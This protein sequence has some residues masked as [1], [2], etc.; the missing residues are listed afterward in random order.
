M[1]LQTTSKFMTGHTPPGMANNIPG[2]GVGLRSPVEEDAGQSINNQPKFRTSVACDTCRD[3]KVKCSGGNPCRYCQK[4]SLE[5]VFQVSRKRKLFP[6]DHV[7]GLERRVAR[8]EAEWLSNLH[9]HGMF[10]PFHLSHGPCNEWSAKDLPFGLG[11]AI[12]Q[13][14]GEQLPTERQNTTFQSTSP[15]GPSPS[16]TAGEIS[17]YQALSSSRTFGAEIHRLLNTPSPSTP[18]QSSP[19]QQQDIQSIA[20]I[21]PSTLPLV[22]CLPS[23][24]AARKYL[25]VVIFYIGQSQHFI[26]ARAFSDNL[27]RLYSN[28]SPRPDLSNV[29][30]VEI[31]LV[32]AVGRQMLHSPGSEDSVSSDTL[33]RAGIAR[34]PPFTGLR[35]EGKAII[36]VL[37]LAAVY[38]QNL[39]LVDDAYYYA[40]T[41]LR[42]C[43]CHQ[44]HRAD[45]QRPLFMSQRAHANR[46]WWTVY[47]QERRL[48]A[49]TGNPVGIPDNSIDIDLPFDAAGFVP[50]GAM[51]VNLTAARIA[52]QIQ[53]LLYS[54]N[55]ILQE[56]FVASVRRILGSLYKATQDIPPEHVL[57]FTVQPLR[58][59]RTSASL[60]LM[61]YQSM[62]HAIRPILLHLAKSSINEVVEWSSTDPRLYKLARTCIAAAQRSLL[63]LITLHHD[64][65][66]GLFGF[67]DLEALFSVGFVMILWKLVGNGDFTNPGVHEICNILSFMA[68]AGN[69]AADQ[70]LRDLRRMD[71]RVLAL[72]PRR[73]KQDRA[74]SGGNDTQ[75]NTLQ[76]SS[77]LSANVGDISSTPGARPGVHA[78]QVDN[79]H[80]THTPSQ[81]SPLGSQSWIAG[82]NL[83]GESLQILQDE[84]FDSGSD[85]Y[86]I[87]YGQ[88]PQWSGVDMQAWDELESY[89]P[90]LR[91]ALF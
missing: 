52:G 5:C 38:L 35:V 91:A 10:F 12:E 43:I 42:I 22:D 16:S 9:D 86:A 73:E 62:M 63:I 15:A 37:A 76:N 55:P 48:A 66:L 90:E 77:T 61:L 2:A 44:L 36:S 34:L 40:S 70:R 3:R 69:K 83:L 50:A 23:E 46:L 89:F 75:P 33:F 78:D 14:P 85:L 64:N 25:E 17:T 49:A 30:I 54:S 74:S 19:S 18:F 68:D 39:D 13:P 84:E 7:Q 87:Y 80:G 59:H 71:D 65:T 26:D 31:L 57:N 1:C 81:H 32:L 47:M 4:R 82:A 11:E 29:E 56:S 27:D 58:V 88:N 6:L 20:Y 28:T 51:A 79:A 53:S 24:N 8:Y 41:A 67:S 45:S 72:I 21:K 60:Y